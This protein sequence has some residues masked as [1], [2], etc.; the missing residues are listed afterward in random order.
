MDLTVWVQNNTDVFVTAIVSLIGS[1][2]LLF[3][4]AI[5]T[6]RRQ[7][8]NQN[9]IYLESMKDSIQTIS[10]LLYDARAMVIGKKFLCES[11]TWRK[12][13]TSSLMIYGSDSVLKIMH[14][15]RR[16]LPKESTDISFSDKESTVFQNY[17]Y[18][19]VS[20]YR[21]LKIEVT[22]T[23]N[24]SDTVFSVFFGGAGADSLKL[25]YNK[26]IDDCDLSRNLKMSFGELYKSFVDAHHKTYMRL[27]ASCCIVIWASFVAPSFGVSFNIA[28]LAHLITTV[29]IALITVSLS[30]A[31]ALNVLMWF[32][33]VFVITYYTAAFISVIM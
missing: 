15:L 16:Y 6:K 26:F 5:E 28:I 10:S 30:I 14:A 11:G 24:N 19:L 8:I 13:Y 20:L 25:L 12:I 2:I 27:Y 29:L 18:C 4:S 31:R 23:S 33:V 9:S 32:P 17:V 3:V 7:K 22:G 1:A 21:Q